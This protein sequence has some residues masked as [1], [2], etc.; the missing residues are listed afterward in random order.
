[1]VAIIS[2]GGDGMIIISLLLSSILI[3]LLFVFCCCSKKVAFVA[4]IA[5]SSSCSTNSG[6]KLASASAAAS[7]DAVNTAMRLSFLILS[8]FNDSIMIVLEEPGPSMLLADS[9]SIGGV[10]SEILA[11]ESSSIS[12][13]K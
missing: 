7:T 2:G 6:D 10:I 13:N 11:T 5:T 1:M 4:T 9:S 8:L 3:L 12:L